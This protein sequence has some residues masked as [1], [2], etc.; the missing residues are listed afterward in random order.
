[1][2]I[3]K[4]NFSSQCHNEN[5]GF[6]V[7]LVPVFLFCFVVVVIYDCLWRNHLHLNFREDYFYFL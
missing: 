2:D 5:T 6:V 1:M 4:M 3:L 7:K